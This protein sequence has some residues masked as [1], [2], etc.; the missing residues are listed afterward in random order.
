MQSRPR[1]KFHKEYFV[2]QERPFRIRQTRR[3]QRRAATQAK[4]QCWY[5]KAQ[6]IKVDDK[7]EHPL[8]PLDIARKVARRCG[9]GKPDNI[10]RRLN[11]HLPGWAVY[12]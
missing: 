11:E 4:Y 12:D 5:D 9:D 2:G 8:S 10:K 6:E 1:S 7:Y 3:E